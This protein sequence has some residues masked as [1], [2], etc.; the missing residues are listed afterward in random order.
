MPGPIEICANG[1]GVHFGREQSGADDNPSSLLVFAA[2]G[3]RACGSISVLLMG[4][5]STV[6]CVPALLG[7]TVLF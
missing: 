3:H 6:L 5:T 4:N 1:T 7:V 2:T